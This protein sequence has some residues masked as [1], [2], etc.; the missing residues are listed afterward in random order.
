[1]ATN[2][3]LGI[4]MGGTNIS[5]GL[6]NENALHGILMLTPCI[7]ALLKVNG[8]SLKILFLM[9]IAAHHFMKK[10]LPVILFL[11]SIKIYRLDLL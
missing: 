4:D 9:N 2:N 1:M 10:A 8:T 11:S 3:I 7:S 6:V 5:G